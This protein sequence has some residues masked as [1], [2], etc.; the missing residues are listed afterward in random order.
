MIEEA[1][2]V[3]KAEPGRR[4]EAM[5]TQPCVWPAWTGQANLKPGIDRLAREA[6]KWR[7]K[8]RVLPNV[9]KSMRSSSRACPSGRAC[10]TIQQR[11]P[12]ENYRDRTEVRD[13]YQLQQS[14]NDRCS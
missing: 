13:D 3:S 12:A 10:P 5:R 4:S 1:L 2:P 6:S 11:R 8:R 9:A 14:R 7:T